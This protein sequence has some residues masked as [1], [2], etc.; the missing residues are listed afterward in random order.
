[1]TLLE[2]VKVLKSQI[3]HGGEVKPCLA[4]VI[5]PYPDTEQKLEQEGD[6]LRAC[7]LGL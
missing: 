1:M 4:V 5:E 7:M 3:E 6:A 2:S